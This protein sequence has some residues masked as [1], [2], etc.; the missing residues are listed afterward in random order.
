[1]WLFLQV[2]VGPILL[3]LG[4]VVAAFIVF[5][6]RTKNPKFDKWL[7]EVW[8]NEVQKETLVVA[9]IVLFFLVAIFK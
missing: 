2:I 3:G 6:V 9:A 7:D 1:M 5:I 4:I 8:P